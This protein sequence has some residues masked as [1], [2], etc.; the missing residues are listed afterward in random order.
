MGP[1]KTSDQLH[2][3][4]TAELSAAGCFRPATARAVGYAVFVVAGYA[5]AYAVPY[6]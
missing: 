2:R 1:N 3:L 4:L 5:A 6:R